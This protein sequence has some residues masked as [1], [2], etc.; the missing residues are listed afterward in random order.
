MALCQD[1]VLPSTGVNARSNDTIIFANNTITFIIIAVLFQTM[2]A[3]GHLS[4]KTTPSSPINY[5]ANKTLK[6]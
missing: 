3:S 6:R 1:E 2:L 5:A 4:F